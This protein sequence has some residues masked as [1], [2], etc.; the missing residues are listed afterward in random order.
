MASFE[1]ATR[2]VVR[3]LATRKHGLLISL[4]SWYREIVEGSFSWMSVI[5]GKDRKCDERLMIFQNG[6][7]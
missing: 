7:I 2:V 6:G 5:A 1:V 3:S 4:F